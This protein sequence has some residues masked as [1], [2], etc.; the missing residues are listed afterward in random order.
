MVKG[1]V[2]VDIDRPI[3]EVFAYISDPANVPEWMSAMVENALEGSGPIGVGSRIKGVGKLLGRRLDFAS[4]VTQYDPPHRLAFRAVISPGK[5]GQG[6]L[7]LES[8]GQRTRL[9]YRAEWE[10]SGLFKLAEP[11]L[12]GLLKRTAETDLQTLKALLEAKVPAGA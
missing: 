2:S 5:G 11:I 7:H 6:E 4:E 8:I 10:T 9:H 12:E 1:E 3:E